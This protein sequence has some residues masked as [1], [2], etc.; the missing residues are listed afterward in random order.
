MNDIMTTLGQVKEASRQLLSLSDAAV[1]HVLR[2]LADAAEQQTDGLL[3][4]MRNSGEVVVYL[5][6]GSSSGK[7]SDFSECL[8]WDEQRKAMIAQVEAMKA[9]RNKVSAQIPQLKKAGQ[10]FKGSLPVS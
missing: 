2:Q 7:D 4:A 1:S 5:E 3:E 6:S 8:V 10:A 9:Q